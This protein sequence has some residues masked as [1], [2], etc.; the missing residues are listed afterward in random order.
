MQNALPLKAR[1]AILELSNL[2][3]AMATVSGRQQVKLRISV[4]KLKYRRA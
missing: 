1:M 2:L 4:I 3:D